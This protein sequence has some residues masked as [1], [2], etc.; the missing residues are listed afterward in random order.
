MA[1]DRL[2][3][4][5]YD[6]TTF[7]PAFISDLAHSNSEIIIESPYITAKR[8]VKLMPVIEK[9]INKGIRVYVL[10]RDPSEHTNTMI[11]EA[12]AII[13]HFEAIGVNVLLC[14]G[15]DHRKLAIIDRNILWEGSLNILSQNES[16]EIMLR[17]RNKQITEETI[18]FLKL[19]KYIFDKYYK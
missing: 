10:T 1:I 17:F 4:D 13:E 12:E 16:R 5:L 11:D 18:K 14:A 15:N 7:Y 3:S 8:M 19:D 9:A 6:E 2:I